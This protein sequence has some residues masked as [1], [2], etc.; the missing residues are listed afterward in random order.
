LENFEMKKTL[1]AVAALVAT[2]AF[3]QVTISGV[4][5][6]AISSA[7]STSSLMGGTINGTEITFGRSEDLGGGMKANFAY[8]V[9]GNL[10]TNAAPANYN[11]YVG[12]SGDFGS[13]KVG[14][15]LNALHFLSA[16]LDLT[17]RT[18][19]GDDLILGAGVTDIFGAAQS[20]NYTSPSMS[21]LSA[22]VQQQ[23]KASGNATN[24]TV[25]YTNGALTAGAGQSVTTGGA[26]VTLMGASYDLGVAKVAYGNSS[27]SAE[28][29]CAS[30][31]INTYSVAAPVGA[32]TLTYTYQDESTNDNNTSKYMA[33]YALSK[34]TK[35]YYVLADAAN[36]IT[37]TK[38]TYVGL[39][40]A[41]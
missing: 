12:L 25:N 1:V 35:A 34:A 8:T 5:E 3:A 2:G 21:G 29:T 33:S 40:H 28:G 37:G 15:V 39:F 9:T 17:G 36:G 31:K 4:M 7:G 16:G 41:F 11:S 18:A 14:S 22:T 26:T 38:T 19:A 30:C 32:F 24:Y 6:A 23:I 13:L 10:A 20:I 27:V